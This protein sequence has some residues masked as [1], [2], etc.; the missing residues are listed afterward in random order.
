MGRQRR[1]ARGRIA[2]G[3]AINRAV[4]RQ[5][6]LDA[7]LTLKEAADGIVTSQALH[8]FEQGQ[9]R[10][11]PDTLAALAQRLHLSVDALLARP[12]DPRELVMRDL[13]V[14]RRWDDLERLATA[15]LDDLNVTPRTQAVARFYLGRAVLEAEP[16]EGLSIMRLARG[17][18]ARVGEHLMAAEA[19]DWESGALYLLQD[20]AAF[21]VGHDA[22]VRYRSLPGRDP[23]V[24][25]RML[26]HIGSYLLQREEVQEAL[27][28]YRRAIDVAGAVPDFARLANLHH[29]LASG[30]SRV[31]ETR[32][33][34][35]YFERAVNLAR[36]HHDM[37]GTFAF[38]LARL[39]N[40][41]GELL[42]RVGQWDRADDMVRSALDH[43]AAAGV[44]AGLTHALLTMG[45]LKHRQGELAEAERWTGEAID[46]A[47]RLGETKSLARGY[48]QLGDLRASQGD[49]DRCDA[50]FTRA[51]EILGDAGLP[52][53][54]AE[55]LRRYARVRQEK[56]EPRC[57][58]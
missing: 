58:S 26:E 38:N 45:D 52:E 4:L 51:L 5:A 55:A 50:C 43:F 1:D 13:E 44:E 47:E 22:L 54:R 53:Q 56:M 30:Y 49:F 31:G 28:F 29:G 42:V 36:V 41:Y 16:V 48:E 19:R 25:A 2:R 27:A 37:H 40:D 3:T 17:Q 7:G 10:P 39:E 21:D 14:E 18:L 20:P 34:L 12:R 11:M 6:R 15:T 23:S 35:D 8:Q 9:T 24:E 32:Q 46:V 33:A 57:G